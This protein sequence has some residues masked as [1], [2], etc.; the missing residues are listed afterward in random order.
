MV[1]LAWQSAYYGRTEMEKHTDLKFWF[2][3]YDPTKSQQT[4]TLT[5]SWYNE[6][7]AGSQT[8]TLT[9]LPVD[10]DVNGFARVRI[11]PKEQKALGTSI[12]FACAT[13]ITIIDCFANWEDDAEGII[14]QHLSV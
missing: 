6:S 10:W 14:P 3:L 9:V 13:K 7:T 2:M 1:P 12:G 5:I 8:A 4:I 11:Q